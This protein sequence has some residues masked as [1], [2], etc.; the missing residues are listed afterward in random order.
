MAGSSVSPYLLYSRDA[1][2][3]AHYMPPARSGF[4]PLH[5]L[6]QG[7]SIIERVF[8]HLARNVDKRKCKQNFCS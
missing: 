8:I 6:I 5:H 2:D 1:R 3:N 7:R 4:S